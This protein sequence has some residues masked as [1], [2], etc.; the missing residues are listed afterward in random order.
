M[1]KGLVISLAG[2]VLLAIISLAAVLVTDSR[3]QLGLDLKGGASVVLQ[4]TSEVSDDTLD[5]TIDIIRRRI[6]SLGVAEPEISRQGSNILVELPGVRDQDRALDIVGRTAQLRFRPVL[7]LLPADENTPT[8]DIDAVLATTTTT[9][10]ATETTAA[11]GASTTSAPTA[12]PT[13]TVSVAAG[14]GGAL[15]VPA[16]QATSTTVAA[17]STTVA[18]DTTTT[19]LPTIIV[20]TTPREEDLA[21]AE[22]VLPQFDDDGNVVGRYRLGPTALTGEAVTDA[23]AVLN[24]SG[25]AWAVSVDF[26]EGPDGLDRLNQLASECYNNFPTCPVVSGAPSGLMAIVLDSVVQSAPS[27]Q[28][29]TFDSD[30]VSISGDF[31]EREAKDL[32][33][34]LRFGALP[35]EL[36]PQAVQTVS[37]TVG[38]DALRAGI[39]AGIVGFALVALLMIA[40]YRL[41]GLVA[42]LGLVLWA[43]LLYSTVAWLGVT[44]GLAL[45]LAGVTGIIMSIGATV[46]SNVVY[47]ERLKDELRAGKSLRSCAERGFKDAF[48]TIIAAGVASLIGA[49]VL[50]LLTVGSVRGFAFFLGLSAILNLVVAYFFTRP[51]IIWIS[52]SLHGD[53]GTKVLGIR[54]GE[55][56]AERPATGAA[57]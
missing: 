50:W 37:A 30:G 18:Q 57:R 27:F 34:V 40:Y 53:R 44:R 22:V 43:V 16:R 6:D 19:S 48:R 12:E 49:G 10:A 8:I 9:V 46:D 54:V 32:A 45:T 38:D 33:T 42:V 23:R 17:T 4:P 14:P 56:L 47:Y 24:A 25:T 21:D 39:V 35:V 20:P 1:R 52:R 51:M 36:E 41:L 55:A 28:T 11:D 5:T 7:E 29:P 13:T 3:P 15:G 2:I 31:S 26:K